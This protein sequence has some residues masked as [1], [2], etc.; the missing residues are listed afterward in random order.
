MIYTS[1]DVA[2]L[3]Y[4]NAK[5]SDNVELKKVLLQDISEAYQRQLT[6]RG[7]EGWY[8]AF[9][10][11]PG[12]LWLTAFCTSIFSEA[13][14]FT[15][16]DDTVLATSADW[17]TRYQKP[18]GSWDPVGFV[19]HTEIVGGASG[20][21]SLSAYVTLA[22]LDT[23]TASAAVLANAR[24]FLEGAIASA[25]SAYELAM[26][27]YALARL[28]S[29]AAEGAASDLLSR[30]ITDEE[31]RLS[32]TPHPVETTAYA[33]LALH[34]IGAHLSANLGA[35]WIVSQ[36]S[37]IGNYG[38]TQDT[39]MALRALVR[40]A[41]AASEAA[42]VTASIAQGGV[43][44]ATAVVNAT[45]FDI[46]QR[47][48][49]VPGAGDVT[50]STAGTG[51]IA[52]QFAKIYHI[53][54]GLVLSRG[55]LELA[56]SYRNPRAVLGDT[57]RGEARV[58]YRAAA[59]TTTNMAVVEVG[60]PTGLAPD[61]AQLAT[62]VG[63]Q[64]VKRVETKERTVVLYLDNVAAG[65]TLALPLTFTAACIAQSVPIVSKAYDYY[66]PA[67]EAL[68]TGMPI[69]VGEA[70]AAIPFVRG[71][72]NQTGKID[73]AD[74]L[75]TLGYLFAHGGPVG[76][77]DACDAN[78]DARVDLS[79][80]VYTLRYL[81]ASGRPPAAPYPALGNDPT[82]DALPCVIK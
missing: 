33:V 32:W 28:G 22:L 55:G 76:C 46:S 44:V 72:A 29:P 69:I 18:N 64:K 79:D 43:T 73:L 12:S 66:N 63:S 25:P 19:I 71:D 59:G 38:S 48:E 42:E 30:A 15:T 34:E 36:R 2:A 17:I 74:V 20:T 41:L 45:N 47:F 80:A 16:I 62:L 78:D 10:D 39:V 21:L 70:G 8:S 11:A 56:V 81:F 27:T 51:P 13:R 1:V 61:R 49:L 7:S 40:D 57:V 3:T 35:A 23:G 68:D 24:S 37:S 77:L 9:G 4:L 50:I 60:V 75:F 26:A 31:G 53:Q 54:E 52:V 58:S 14:A 67:I 82:E 5:G 65:E 6:Y